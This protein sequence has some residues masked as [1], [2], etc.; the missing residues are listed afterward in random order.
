[1]PLGT[2]FCNLLGGYLAGFIAAFLLE[3]PELAALRPLLVT[4]FLG[5]L[6]TFSTF[7]LEVVQFL[8]A[9]RFLQAAFC[10][11]AHLAG[12]VLLTLA[13][14]SSYSFVHRLIAGSGG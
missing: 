12:S 4:G 1:M 10:A 9:G 3:R 11:T 6:T 5:A 8:D 7:S 13:G 2:L 14:Y